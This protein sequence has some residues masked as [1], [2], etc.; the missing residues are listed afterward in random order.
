[1]KKVKDTFTITNQLHSVGD[2]ERNQN[3][4]VKEFINKDKEKFIV[5]TCNLSGDLYLHKIIKAKSIGYIFD[6]GF[7]PLNGLNAEAKISQLKR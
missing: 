3:I 6:Q 2:L 1:M 5:Y 4:K 7:E